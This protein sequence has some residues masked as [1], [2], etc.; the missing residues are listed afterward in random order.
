MRFP[1][2]LRWLWLTLVVVILDRATKA[3]IESRPIT[4]FPH[5]VIPNWFD[6]IYSKNPGIA[7]SFFSDSNGMTTRIILIVGSLLIIALI[8]WL[9]VAGRDASG[10]NAAGLALLLGGAAGNLTDRI[11]HG[12]V[13]DFLQV[14][15]RFLHVALFNPWPTFNVADTAVTIGALLLIF[16]VVLH[17]G[18]AKQN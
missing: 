9:L 4:F 8:A 10:V 2:R 7:F 11:V 16:D 15:L 6:I 5:V 18:P 14:W 1:E 3:W 13:T 12:A 17:P